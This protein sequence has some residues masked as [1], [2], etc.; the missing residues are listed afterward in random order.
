MT[1]ENKQID[2]DKYKDIEQI[3]LMDR[4]EPLAI[5]II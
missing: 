3:T 1:Q 5:F 2:L 4:Q